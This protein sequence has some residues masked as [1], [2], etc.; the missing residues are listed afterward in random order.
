MRH[1]LTFLLAASLL[2]CASYKNNILLKATDTEFPEVLSAEAKGAEKEYLI[3]TYDLLGLDVYSNSGE[4]LIDP[5]PELSNATAPTPTADNGQ[6]NRPT[7]MVDANGLTKLP[8]VGEMKLEGLTLRQAEEI[9]QKEYAKFFKEP[10]V[11][12]SFTN[13]RVIV[14]GAPLGGQV[15]PLTSQ[16]M[17]VAEVLAISKSITND[18]RAN[19]IRLVRKD[20]VYHIDLSTIKGF[21]EGN[22]LVES[23]DIIYVEPVRRP[24]TEGLRDNYLIGSL[25]IAIASLAALIRS[26]K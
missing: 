13:K 6:G 17:R 5:N 26:V 19:N 2:S 16:N 18:A 25:L 10:F 9:L 14:L 1:F 12:I 24:F 11:Q 21:K 15:V 22:I 7:Y 20:H 4:R 8:M 23:G 3:R